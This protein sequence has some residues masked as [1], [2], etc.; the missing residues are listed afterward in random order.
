MLVYVLTDTSSCQPPFCYMKTSS[1]SAQH[2]ADHSLQLDVYWVLSLSAQSGCP[3]MPLFTQCVDWAAH[4]AYHH[5]GCV[6]PTPAHTTAA[7][8]TLRGLAWC[9][10]SF[11]NITKLYYVLNHAGCWQQCTATCRLRTCLN[12][13]TLEWRAFM[14]RGRAVCGPLFLPTVVLLSRLQRQ[15]DKMAEQVRFLEPSLPAA[16]LQDAADL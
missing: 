8:T 1:C 4:Y 16:A 12:P 6:P 15:T 5:V 2:A 11:E 9:V 13:S 14:E 3:E 10:L 7:T